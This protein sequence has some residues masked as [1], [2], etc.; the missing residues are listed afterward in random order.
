M[1]PL[2]VALVLVSAFLHAGWNLFGKGSQDKSAFFLAQGAC[3]A[4]ICSPGLIAFWSPPPTLG[5]VFVALSAAAHAGYALYL[6]K[7]YEAGD[8]SIAYPISRSAPALVLLWEMTAG[9]QRLSV[10]GVSGVV[11]AVVGA[12]M[13]QW[14]LLRARG[15]R[16]VLRADVTRFAL[17]TAV[18]IAAFTIVDK[19]GVGQM[20]PFVFLVLILAGEFPVFIVRMGS[21]TATR[22][23]AEWNRTRWTILAT[24]IVGP[25]SYLLI[26][27]ALKNAPATYV[28]SL[29]QTSIVFGV[30]LGRF[31]L[32]EVGTRYPLIGA[33]VITIG[34]LLIAA[35]G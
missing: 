29:R 8:L 17:I 25:F 33:V 16:G 6:V 28:L 12:L 2:A 24:A 11:L 22:V 15:L 4:I 27:W 5:W 19:Q 10:L 7:S 34:G 21:A 18:F 31:V 20:H 9:H 35:G 13:V 1:T 26:L 32:G 23:R 30:V 14:P 3:T